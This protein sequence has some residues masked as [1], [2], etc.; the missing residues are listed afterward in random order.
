MKAHC[1]DSGCRHNSLLNNEISFL[2]S[3]PY[4]QCLHVFK[5]MIY[6]YNV[7]EKHMRQEEDLFRVYIYIYTVHSRVYAQ[8]F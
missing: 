6:E 3:C 5:Q 8:T 1:C 7:G 4:R 2:K